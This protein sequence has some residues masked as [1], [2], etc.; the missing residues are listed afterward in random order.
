MI[1]NY[2]IGSDIEFFLKDINGDPVSGEGIIPGDKYDPYVIENF[3]TISLDNVSA[4]VTI[5]PVT[6]KKDF[7]K[8]IDFMT[9]YVTEYIKNKNLFLDIYPARMFKKE[10]VMTEHAQLLG[11]Q[12]DF[13]MR[14]KNENPAPQVKTFHGRSCGKIAC[15]LV[16]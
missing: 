5:N 9:R 11:C 10:Q 13:S 1:K 8:E 2:T 3:R 16:K 15:H 4:E 7:I 12:S 14:L 6:T